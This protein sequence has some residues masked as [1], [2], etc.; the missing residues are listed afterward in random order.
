MLRCP[1]CHDGL[2]DEEGGPARLAR[3]ACSGCGAAHHG[4]CLL[5][6]ARCAVNGCARPI[7]PQQAAELR[8]RGVVPGADRRCPRCDH[9][10]RARDFSRG[11]LETWLIIAGVGVGLVVLMTAS[12]IL[13]PQPVGAIVAAVAVQA[14]VQVLIRTHQA[15]RAIVRCSRCAWSGSPVLLVRPATPVES[16]PPGAPP[17]TRRPDGKERAPA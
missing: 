6:L 3:V 4:A 14:A 9:R 8:A 1:Y 5:E 11:R 13:A 7:G 15:R 17:A 16:A 12:A 2:S 10:V